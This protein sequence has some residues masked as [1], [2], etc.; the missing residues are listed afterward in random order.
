MD[1]LDV[2]D[3]NGYIFLQEL[4]LT[5]SSKSNGL[6]EVTPIP[7]FIEFYLFNWTNPGDLKKPGVKPIVEEIGPFVYR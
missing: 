1:D 7:M 6:W 5:K 4:A 2:D 3:W